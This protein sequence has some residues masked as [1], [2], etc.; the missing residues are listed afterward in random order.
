MDFDP[1]LV[2][3]RAS[4]AV[5]AAS[6][7]QPVLQRGRAAARWDG[8]SRGRGIVDATQL[9]S[10]ASEL[11]AAFR[12]P[13]WV[14]EQPKLHLLPPVDVWCEQHRTLALSGAYVSQRRVVS[15]GNGSALKLRFEVGTG[16]LARDAASSPT[17]HVV[18]INVAGVL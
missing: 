7:F 8:D 13:S 17:D 2:Y 16:E 5:S 6:G 12:Q 9:V 4:A 3:P 1:R 15:V 14:A 10:G 18:V 11:I